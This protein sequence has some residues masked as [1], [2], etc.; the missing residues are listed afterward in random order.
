MTDHGNLG[1][2]ADRMLDALAACTDEPDR[3]T[4]L[5]FGPAH[6]AAADLVRSWMD[7]AGLET[8]I[9]PVGN[10]HG[11][12]AA[13][14]PSARRRLLIGSHIDT[15]V[16]A[17]RFDGM[18]GVVVGILAAE[19]LTVDLPFDLELLAFGDEEGLRFP[20]ASIGSLSLAGDVPPDVF[21]V[22][23]GAGVPLRQAL[24]DFGAQERAPLASLRRDPDSLVGYLEVH[25]EQG[26]VLEALG[27]PLGVVTSIAAA[28]RLRV[29]V[30]GP[31]GHAGTVPMAMRRDPLV[32]VAEMVLAIEGIT[33]GVGG[34][35]V[36]TVGELSLDAA[37]ANAIPRS[38][39]FTIDARAPHDDA[40]DRVVD[41][42]VAAIGRIAAS[43]GVQAD[44]RTEYRGVAT[45][46]DAELSAAL[47]AACADLGL[48][49]PLLP[50]GAG[51][52]AQSLALVT[53]VAMLFVRCLEGR[54]HVPAECAAPDDIGL[55]VAGLVGALGVLA[56]RRTASAHEG[57]SS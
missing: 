29:I 24:A 46:C 51:H 8:W 38:V 6:R 39:V 4:R 50:S 32:A 43:R 31:G 15:V 2:R 5:S 22:V 3:M 30:T 26:P 47:S 16:D 9:D 36:A 53:P 37:A 13:M 11:L 45:A 54:S 21:D 34:D 28:A 7:A 23:D 12:R 14:A 42:I 57:A 1:A 10:V 18:L 20:G 44:T 52:D 40:L 17:G 49:A 48:S 33:R 35:S 41:E 55:A 25:I 19:E 27:A 56:T